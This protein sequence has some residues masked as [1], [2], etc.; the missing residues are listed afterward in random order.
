MSQSRKKIFFNQA[1]WV[2]I[3]FWL[4]LGCLPHFNLAKAELDPLTEAK[5]TPSNTNFSPNAGQPQTTRLIITFTP[6]VNIA[7]GGFIS[8]LI[9]SSTDVNK[10]NDGAADSDGFDINK[11]TNTNIDSFIAPIGFSRS[12]TILTS[13]SGIHYLLI[14]LSSPLVA[15]SEYSFSVGSTTN[16]DFRLVNPKPKTNHITGTADIY[17]L[18]IQIENASNSI[19]GKT[20]VKLAINDEFTTSGVTIA[21]KVGGYYFTLFGYTSPLAVVTMEGLSKEKQTIADNQGYFEFKNHPS[22]L[23]PKEICLS[24]KDQ[25][26][27][28]SAPLCLPPFPIDANVTIGPV[29]MPPT[30]SLNNSPGGVYFTGDETILSGQTLPKTEVDLSV[31][32]D[33]TNNP[34][35]LVVKP[36]EAL[37]FPQLT[38]KSDH[39]GNFSLSLPSSQP[40]FFHLFAQ[41]N[42]KDLPSPQSIT[43]NVKI[44][45]IWMIIWLIIKGRFIEIIIAAQILGLIIYFLRRYLHPHLIARERAITLRGHFDLVKED[46]DMIIQ[47]K[48]ELLER[49]NNK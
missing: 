4:F 21:A 43:L 1:L 13:T 9:P 46:T 16:D 3:F 29:I 33:T 19:L 10:S 35:A 38:T 14:T 20:I 2:M 36:V 7:A 26:G 8:V 39:K 12:S 32:I 44:L 45:P 37:T 48:M 41:A 25:L 11:L 30:V 49:F 17:P 22:P 15:G 18:A 23:A 47:R 5:V 42:Y 31:F 34:L 24:A 28:V 6:N 27:R 40:D